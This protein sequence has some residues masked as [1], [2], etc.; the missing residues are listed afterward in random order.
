V[1][2]PVAPLGGE[3]S[4][5]GSKAEWTAAVAVTAVLE[6]TKKACVLLTFH[7]IE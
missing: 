1:E 6:L 2:T 7:W 4:V 5:G 3:T